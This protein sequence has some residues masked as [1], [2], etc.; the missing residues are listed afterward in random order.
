MKEIYMWPINAEQ[1]FTPKQV[2]SVIESVKDNDV[3]TIFCE[4]TVNDEG[5][6]Q[7]AKTTGARL[8][9]I[10]MSI[11]SRLKHGPVPTYSRFCWI[12]TLAPFRMAC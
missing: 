5:Q 4:S 9:A 2:Q 1:Q 7:V 3:P 10:S 6:K 11:R 12:T 8:A